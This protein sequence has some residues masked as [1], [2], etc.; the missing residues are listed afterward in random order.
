MKGLVSIITPCFNGE[1]YIARFLDSVLTQS[2]NDIEVIVINDGSTDRTA[3]I[4]KGYESKFLDRGYIFY[5]VFQENNGA[6]S[7]INKG[8]K[9][10]SGE[11]VTWP[12]SDDLLHKDS[13]KNKVN[14]LID[15]KDY[16][17]VRTDFTFVN[18]QKIEEVYYKA[19]DVISYKNENIFD[20][21]ITERNVF[22][23]PG[24]YM[25]TKNALKKSI[26]D[27]NIYESKAG[28]NW[29][30]LLPVALNYK[31]GYLNQSLFTYVVRDNSHSRSAKSL[32]DEINKCDEHLDIF[33]NVLSQLNVD[34]MKYNLFLQNK[35]ERKKF[36]L[37]CTYQDL[38]QSEIHFGKIKNRKATDFIFIISLR[39]GFFPILNR[40]IPYAN[41][42]INYIRKL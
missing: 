29:Q 10:F 9:L 34:N 26:P 7:A 3:E 1:K 11:Y 4:I 37:S 2:Y 36:K 8:L 5:Y 35:Y 16:S 39:L 13:I 20:D 21:F 41:S 19:S 15:N 12:D 14:Y 40:I 6:A 38:Q 22:C 42:F 28:Q 33:N 23:C 31:C 24:S 30:I 32:Q 18:E 17:F 25:V 27:N